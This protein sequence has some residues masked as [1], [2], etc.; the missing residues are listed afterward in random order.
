MSLL[1]ELA[2]HKSIQ[3]ESLY[4]L[5]TA[6]YRLELHDE[7]R[8]TLK[9]LLATDPTNRPALDLKAQVEHVLKKE[10]AIGLAVLSA[11]GGLALAVGAALIKSRAR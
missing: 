6:Q 11:A 4:Y 9:Q 5:A 10:G 1:K 3:R 7:A 8:S 2:E